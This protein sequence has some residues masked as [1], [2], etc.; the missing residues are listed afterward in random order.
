MVRERLKI[1]M[2]RRWWWFGMCPFQRSAEA[3][4]A[5]RRAPVTIVAVRYPPLCFACA[6]ESYQTMWAFLL[7]SHSL[8]N[9]SAAI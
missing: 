7:R 4:I 9:G 2:C 1:R 6:F 3:A 5:R 8:A